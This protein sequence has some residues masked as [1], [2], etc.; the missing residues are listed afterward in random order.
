ML[1]TTSYSLS[2][3]RVVGCTRPS[4]TPQWTHMRQSEQGLAMSL[5]CCVASVHVRVCR[6]VH[7]CVCCVRASHEVRRPSMPAEIV[8]WWMKRKSWP[9][10]WYNSFQQHTHI[11]YK[12]CNIAINLFIY[13]H[14]IFLYL[15][16]HFSTDVFLLVKISSGFVTVV[17]QLWPQMPTNTLLIKVTK[18]TQ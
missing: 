10:Y 2:A 15:A 18:A 13:I 12:Q 16:V 14:S 1:Q 9:I 3:K 11:L 7:V 8:Q 17:K 4:V 6:C 5:C